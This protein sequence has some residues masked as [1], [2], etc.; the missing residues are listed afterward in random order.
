MD[1]EETS[2]SFDPNF[3]CVKVIGT[4]KRGFIEFEFSIG[5]PDLYVEL[6]LPVVAFKAFCADWQVHLIP[7]DISYDHE[8]DAPG[9]WGVD[10]TQRP[11]API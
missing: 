9:G 2:R 5:Q 11:Q 4:S 8:G 6:V 10:S 1:E 7:S 3:R